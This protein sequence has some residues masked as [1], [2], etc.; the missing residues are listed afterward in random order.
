M[1]FT[2]IFLIL[3]SSTFL[4]YT[5]TA[6][7]ELSG[8]SYG[9]GNVSLSCTPGLLLVVEAVQYKQDHQCTNNQPRHINKQ[10]LK[11]TNIAD[12]VYRRVEPYNQ[13]SSD[14]RVEG[15]KGVERVEDLRDVEERNLEIRDEV[16]KQ[17]SGAERSSCRFNLKQSLP[18]LSLDGGLEVQY[19]CARNVYSYCGGNVQAVSGGYISSPGY[20]KYYLGGR[21]CVWILAGG[22]GQTIRL[23][24]LDADLRSEDCIEIL[25]NGLVIGKECGKLVEIKQFRST[26]HSLIIRT[27]NKED[28]QQLQSRRGVLLKYKT[29]GCASPPGI[30]DGKLIS[31]N[32]S[33]AEF[34]CNK[35][36]V[37]KSTL[38][39]F[40]TMVCRENNWSSLLEHCVSIE[41]LL[42]YGGEEVKNSLSFS[43]LQLIQPNTVDSVEWRLEVGATV[44]V[45]VLLLVSLSIG[46]LL[47]LKYS[48]RGTYL[49]QDEEV[50][51]E[52][53]EHN[54]HE[55]PQKY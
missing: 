28:K 51:L 44:V 24:I 9:C 21:P 43:T 18:H 33:I 48:E 32:G 50:A 45:G 46:L 41:F 40:K 39:S 19:T 10:T 2:M 20:P 11:Y 31:S 38:T 47:Y 25:D 42:L 27:V 22:A 6:Q 49:L 26:G 53:A 54:F 17:C 29:I 30:A 14:T 3:Y 13:I 23:E 55:T 12:P 35:G 8:L 34:A 7:D 36:H 15:V 1:L 4:L 52:E 16:V 37:F 5:T